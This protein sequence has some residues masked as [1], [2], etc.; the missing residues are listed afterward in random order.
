MVL[1]NYTHF[2]VN[3]TQVTQKKF[4]RDE[5]WDRIKHDIKYFIKILMNRFNAVCEWGAF[6]EI[7]KQSLGPT[8]ALIWLHGL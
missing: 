3:S 7:Q 4:K 6:E 2:C 5:F 1:V 8:F